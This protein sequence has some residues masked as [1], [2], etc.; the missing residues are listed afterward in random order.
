MK[1]TGTVDI[2]TSNNDTH[3][4]SETPKNG[5]NHQILANEIESDRAD[6]SLTL[7]EQRIGDRTPL[8]RGYKLHF[9]DRY[10]QLP[11]YTPHWFPEKDVERAL[12]AYYLPVYKKSGETIGQDRYD[13]TD[14]GSWVSRPS[15]SSRDYLLKLRNDLKERDDQLK[16]DDV[17]KI[18]EALEGGGDSVEM[19]SNNRSITANVQIT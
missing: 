3:L 12:D 17:R 11:G 8:G 9:N 19:K 6:P 2:N 18:D 14:M 5:K 10:K 13:P 16:L 1:K 7:E 4:E 15:G